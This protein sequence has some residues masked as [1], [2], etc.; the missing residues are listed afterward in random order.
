MELL[1]KEARWFLS[2]GGAEKFSALSSLEERII[3]IYS[4]LRVV[5]NK[6]VD[7]NN[8]LFKMS[9]FF[10]D[11]VYHSNVEYS[12]Y[13]YIVQPEHNPFMAYLMNADSSQNDQ[14]L[15]L[16]FT[17]ILHDKV[18]VSKKSEWIYDNK[19]LKAKDV[20]EQL[21]EKGIKYLPTHS[22]DMV[23]PTVYEMEDSIKFLQLELV[24]LFLKNN[25][26]K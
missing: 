21:A 24:W 1:K 16:I 9:I 22:M 17:S 4:Y 5:A 7:E 25:E 11:A 8:L 12:K 3:F 18:N 14:V 2:Q 26:E 20:M 15:Y 6:E 23:E 13:P 19:L 10:A